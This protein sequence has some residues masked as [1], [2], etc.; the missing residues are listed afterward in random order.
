MEI[1]KAL[2]L[3]TEISIFWAHFS[4]KQSMKELLINSTPSMVE[5]SKSQQLNL[6]MEQ[7]NKK[8]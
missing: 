7:L 4:D 2:S 6:T 1:L 8:K 3:L 5:Y